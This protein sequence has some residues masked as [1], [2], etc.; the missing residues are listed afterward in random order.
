MVSVSFVS[1]VKKYARKRPSISPF[2]SP[3]KADPIPSFLPERRHFLL[4]GFTGAL[5]AASSLTGLKSP[6]GKAGPGKV[7]PAGLLRPPASLPEK[8]FLSRCVRCGEC[9]AACP[10]NTL[11]PLWFEAGLMGLFSPVL[12]P[13][14]GYCIYDCRQCSLVCPTGAITYLAPKERLWAKTGTAVIHKEQCLAWEHKK[15]CMVCDEVCPFKAVEFHFQE[16][17]PV[18]VP[19]VHEER[20]TGCGY[21]EHYCPVQNQSAISGFPHGGHQ[22]GQR[23]IPGNGQEAGTEF[24]PETG[25]VF[26]ISACSERGHPR[27]RPPLPGL[28]RHPGDSIR[29]LLLQT[30]SGTPE[31]QRVLATIY[32]LSLDFLRNPF[33]R[34][35][36]LMDPFSCCMRKAR[37]RRVPSL[38]PI[39]SVIEARMVMGCF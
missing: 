24:F 35:L 3:E 7:A 12:T 36:T 6:G 11:Q 38:P 30:D 25:Q 4:A 10:T 15:G 18:P 28:E 20:C 1:P 17:N 37:V 39:F 13:K 21:C 34:P 5:T 33:A 32:E 27:S 22:A 19:E 23:F 2:F 9:L 26:R 8:E 16:G 14:R 31:L 29:E